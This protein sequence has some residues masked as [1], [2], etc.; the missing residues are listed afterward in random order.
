MA[1]SFNMSRFML[2]KKKKLKRKKD[3]LLL[4]QM[5]LCYDQIS[6]TASPPAQ[7]FS[8]QMFL[9]LSIIYVQYYLKALLAALAITV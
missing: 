5:D 4:L 6:I 8:K 3:T 2:K 7:P 1:I 9:I